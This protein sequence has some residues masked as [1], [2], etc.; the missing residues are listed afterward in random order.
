MFDNDVLK[1][2]A[3]CFQNNIDAVYGNIKYFGNNSVN[4]EWIVGNYKK[5]MF[6][7]GWSIPFPSFFFKRILLKKYGL[8]DTNIRIADDYDLIFRFVHVHEIN[9]YYLDKFLVKFYYHG[10]SGNILG[11]VRSV[12]D[13]N[14]IFN[15]Y[16]INTNVIIFFLKKYFIKLKQYTFK[17]NE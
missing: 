7:K 8:L 3:K 9:I 5:G 2:V 15:K 16:N 13:I 10:R 1:N 4:R 17:I 6:L 12:L 14:Y 11:R